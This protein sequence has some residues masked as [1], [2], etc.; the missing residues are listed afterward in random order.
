MSNRASC[1][2]LANDRCCVGSS[3]RTIAMVPAVMAVLSCELS[4][5]G[6]S[7]EL[8]AGTLVKRRDGTVTCG[9]DEPSMH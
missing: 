5:E 1:D 8:Q 3:C 4:T 7:M 6:Y 2:V 9:L